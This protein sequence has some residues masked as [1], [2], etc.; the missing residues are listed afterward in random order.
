MT[1]HKEQTTWM[2]EMLAQANWF[3]IQAKPHCE[4]LAAASLGNLDL[5]VF[6][7]RIR[8]EQ[9]LFGQPRSL[10]VPLFRGYLFA[11]FC[12]VVSLEAVRYAFAVARVLGNSD[13]PIPVP[14]EII[15]ELQG[16]MQADG[17]IRREPTALRLGQQ[18]TI[19]QGPFEGL[20]GRVEQEWDDGKRVAILLEGIN[21]A[22]VL[23]EKR[24]LS[25]MAKRV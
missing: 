11:R 19:E 8:Q 20:M 22:R 17:F 6:L 3:A 4:D 25:V 15:S 1:P 21:K 2:T 12:P 9:F 24:W 14:P 5:E 18:V 10:V 7:P 23:I 13:G 16:R